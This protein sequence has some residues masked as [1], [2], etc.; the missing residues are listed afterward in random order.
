MKG[1]W[2]FAFLSVL[3]FGVH[4]YF[5]LIAVSWSP[6]ITP[7]AE[8]QFWSLVLAI[9][10]FPLG[11][12]LFYSPA[13]ELVLLSNSVLWGVVCGWVAMRLLTWFKSHHELR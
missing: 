1:N 7:S 5:T 9:L 10:A 2:G 4:M 11:Y 12:L 13:I 8:S 3:F 6:A